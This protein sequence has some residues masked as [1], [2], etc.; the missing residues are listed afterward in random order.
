MVCNITFLMIRLK[1]MDKLQFLI[2]III[3]TII[4][5]ERPGGYRMDYIRLCLEFSIKYCSGHYMHY[6]EHFH[7]NDN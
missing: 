4:I 1:T 5:N 7:H 3:I 2:F 6:R